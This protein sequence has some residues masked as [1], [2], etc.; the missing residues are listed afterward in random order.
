MLPSKQPLSAPPRLF[1]NPE[2][3]DGSA[4]GQIHAKNAT[5]RCRDVEGKMFEW[6][7][8]NEASEKSGQQV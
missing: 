4:T 1:P 5:R 2:K 8:V 6:I 7:W 3:D